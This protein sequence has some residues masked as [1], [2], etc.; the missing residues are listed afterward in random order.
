MA[1]I[2]TKMSWLIY[3]I[4]NT[5]GGSQISKRGKEFARVKDE[6]H[7]NH[8]TANYKRTI[9]YIGGHPTSKPPRSQ[10]AE[11]KY[12]FQFLQQPR[13]PHFTE[14][15]NMVQKKISIQLKVRPVLTTGCLRARIEI[16]LKGIQIL[17]IQPH[18]LTI[19]SILEACSQAV[20]LIE[21]GI[22][23]L[24]ALVF[25]VRWPLD[26]PLPWGTLGSRTARYS[27]KPTAGAATASVL[28]PSPPSL[29][30]GGSW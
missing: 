26:G 8:M 4:N 2:F 10:C 14:Q 13:Y 24:L 5:D 22:L 23:L 20:L 17:S 1:H 12:N 30:A 18:M 6:Q 28:P 9:Y 15:E 29:Q 27:D 16:G 3:N 11:S 19:L 7:K 21:T 25:P